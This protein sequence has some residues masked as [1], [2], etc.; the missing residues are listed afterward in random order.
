MSSSTNEPGAL[1]PEEQRLRKFYPECLSLPRAA[2]APSPKDCPSD[3]MTFSDPS[4]SRPTSRDSSLTNIEETDPFALYRIEA[5]NLIPC[6]PVPQSQPENWRQFPH[7]SIPEFGDYYIY[8]P[9]ALAKAV[10]I[11]LQSTKQT[12]SQLSMIYDD[13]MATLSR[14]LTSART[15]HEKRRARAIRLGMTVE[16]E[17]SRVREL[18]ANMDTNACG[19]EKTLIDGE[20]KIRELEEKLWKARKLA[21][22]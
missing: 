22:L 10:E 6:P 1:T 21:G 3:F 13:T 11:E 20:N 7:S 16:E 18:K 2:S 9:I 19:W 12:L 8:S 5:S 17:S 15:S 14:S 4:N